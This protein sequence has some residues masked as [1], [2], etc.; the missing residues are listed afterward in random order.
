MDSLS[1]NTLHLM[2]VTFS[3]FKLSSILKLK[4][5][6]IISKALKIEI[7]LVSLEISRT[8]LLMI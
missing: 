3:L 4:F 2:S 8:A 1:S 5:E 6:K 7:L